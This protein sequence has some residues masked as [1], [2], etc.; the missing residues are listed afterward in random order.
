MIYFAL[1]QGI[2]EKE[3]KTVIL[4]QVKYPDKYK[5][6]YF[7][8]ASLVPSNYIAIGRIPWV[9]KILSSSPKPDYYPA[10]MKPYLYRKIWEADKWPMNKGIFIKPSDI[11]K[12][13]QHKVTTGTYKGKKKPPYW[14]SDIVS[15][16]NEWRYY[17]AN[18]KI[19]FVGWY[20]G[21]DEDT[22][23]PDFPV[24]IIPNNWCGSIDMGILSSGEFALV[25]CGEPYSTG[26]YGTYEQGD[27]YV[28]WLIE[29][30]KYLQKNKHKR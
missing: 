15:F 4:Q 17:V 22:A 25:E 16:K 23:P 30:W 29:G 19:V 6:N 9:Q 10:F 12:R 11:P 5:V 2:S 3:E 14:C 24:N 8:D 27:V 7:R 28:Q 21:N 20:A 1:E 13:F 18:G 26:W